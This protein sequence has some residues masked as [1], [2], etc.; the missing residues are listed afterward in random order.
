MRVVLSVRCFDLYH[1][2]ISSRVCQKAL[3]TGRLRLLFFTQSPMRKSGRMG[4][5]LRIWTSVLIMLFSSTSSGMTPTP[6]PKLT[7]EMMASWPET[8]P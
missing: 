8:W 7:S 1:D 5:T 2:S 6:K 3:T 4:L